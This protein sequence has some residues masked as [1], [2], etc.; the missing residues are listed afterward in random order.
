MAPFNEVLSA[1][2]DARKRVWIDRSPKHHV[3]MNRGHRGGNS[4]HGTLPNS[5]SQPIYV[6]GKYS[7]SIHVTSLSD[8]LLLICRCHYFTFSHQVVSPTRRKMKF[9]ASAMD[10]LLHESDVIHY[11]QCSSNNHYQIIQ[12][13]YLLLNNNF[14]IRI[15]SNSSQGK[16]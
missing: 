11:N 13:M 7:V 12:Q 8:K 9:M 3:G 16:F 4:N 1:L 10:V 5:H 2:E 6:P 15:N 14:N